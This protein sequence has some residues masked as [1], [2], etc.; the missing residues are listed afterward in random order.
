MTLDQIK[1]AVEAGKIVHW[2]NER[3]TVIKDNIGQ[4]LIVFDLG[5]RN[6]F[7]VDL[8]WKDGVTLIG[9]PEEFYIEE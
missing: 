6:E 9:C 4:W 2:S 1:Q 3:Y 5:G 7:A 8:V